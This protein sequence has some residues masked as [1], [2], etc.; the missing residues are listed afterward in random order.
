M[1]DLA[2]ADEQAAAPPSAPEPRSAPARR[3]STLAQLR[4]DENGLTTLEWLLIVAAVAGLAA[5]AVVLVQNVVSDTSDQIAGDSARHTAALLAA[6]EIMRDADRDAEDQPRGAKTFDDWERH[7]TEKCER[8]EITYGDAQIETFTKFDY[9][10]T[11]GAVDDPVDAD[12][13]ETFPADGQAT[14]ASPNPGYAA[15]A[16]RGNP[17]PG[18]VSTDPAGQK[19]FAHCVISNS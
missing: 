13:I 3:T 12:D 14:S 2:M 4:R 16:P 11:G 6:D 9:N 7:Y 18:L 1:A 19:A 8:L 5:L 10:D 15:G 17:T